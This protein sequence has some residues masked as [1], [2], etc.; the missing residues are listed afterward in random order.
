MAFAIGERTRVAAPTW[1]QDF[2]GETPHD[3]SRC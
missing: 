1:D 3:P 2:E